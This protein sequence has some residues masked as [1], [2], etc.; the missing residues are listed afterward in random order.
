[1]LERRARR[2]ALALFLTG[3]VGRRSNHVRGLFMPQGWQ[4]EL[5]GTDGAE[6]K[7]QTAVDIAVKAEELL[8][9]LA[10]ARPFLR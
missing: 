8:R 3:F 2:A 9:R 1:M 6:A 10:S 5:A 4:M 7:W